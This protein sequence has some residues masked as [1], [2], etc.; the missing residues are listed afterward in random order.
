MKNI[1]FIFIVLSFISITS[2]EVAEGVIRSIEQELPLTEDEV[3]KGLKEALRVSTDT[4]VSTV[5]VI[6]GFYKDQAIKILLPP[7]A[8]IIT[9][10]MNHPMLKAIGITDMINDVILRMNRAAENAAKEATPIFINSIKSMTIN[11]AFD[12]LNGSD[13]AATHYFR[14]KTYHQLKNK[15]RPNITASLNK[16]LVGNISANKAWSTLTDGYNQ[17]ANYVPGWKKVN[18]QLDDYVTTKA[19]NGLFQKLGE[20]EIQIRKNPLARVTE[21]LERVFGK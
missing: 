19:L 7:E 15:F 18:T 6:N 11:D 13:T 20:E 1:F 8:D 21:I 3:V 5:S 10:N 12:I 9:D 14:K 2:C 4:A 17:V 16:P